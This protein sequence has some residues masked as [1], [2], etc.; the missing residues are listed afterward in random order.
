LGG[1]DCGYEEFPGSAMGE[2]A[3]DVRIGF[4]EGF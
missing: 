4:V 3:F 2:G 1:E